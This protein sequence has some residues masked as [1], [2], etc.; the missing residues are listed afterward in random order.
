MHLL[1]GLRCHGHM[2]EGNGMVQF[3]EEEAE[4]RPYCSVHIPDIS[5]RARGN[6]LKLCQGRFR[7]D[8]KKHFISERVVMHW[9]RLPGEV[10]RWWSH[11]L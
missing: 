9:S 5:N 4:G 11:H 10:W 2:A 3:G 6:G 7:L 8:I 1:S